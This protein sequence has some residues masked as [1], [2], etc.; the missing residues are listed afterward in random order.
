MNKNKDFFIKLSNVD[1]DISNFDPEYRLI[2]SKKKIKKNQK[3]L[4][5]ISL[6]IKNSE[7]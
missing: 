5:N 4:N 2:N 3:I 6:K 7:K 1:L